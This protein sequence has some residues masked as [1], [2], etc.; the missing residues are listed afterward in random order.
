LAGALGAG[1][2]VAGAFFTAAFFTADFLAGMETTVGAGN[3]N[4]NSGNTDF[5]GYHGHHR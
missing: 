3:D 5:K 1:A 2:F 4:S